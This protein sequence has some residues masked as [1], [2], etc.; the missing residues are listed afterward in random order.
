M[1]IRLLLI[2]AL[3]SSIQLYAQQSMYYVDGTG[4]LREH[5]G[6]KEVAFAG[7]NYTLPFAHAY[8]AHKQLGIDLKSAIDNDVYHLSRLGFNAFRLHVWDIEITD[9]EGNLLANEH[10]NLLDYLVSK[11]KERNIRIVL[12]PIAYWGNGYPERDEKKDGFSSRWDKC[13]ITRNE[14][15]IKAQENYLSQFMK[16]INPYTGI[17]LKDEPDIVGFEINN[18]PCNAASPK[19]TIAYVNRMSGAISKSG[20]HKP[21]FY[22]VSHN[23]QNTQAFY[24]AKIDG[25]TFQWYPTGLV[26]GHTR[27]GNFLPAVDRYPIP[28]NHIKNFNKKARLVYEFDAADIAAPYIYPAIART[29]RSAGFQWVTQFAYDP[30]GMAWANTEYQTHYLNL[31]YTPQKAI[32]MKIA[33]EVV[34][35]TPRFATYGSYPGDTLFGDFR[36]SYNERLSEMNTSEKFFYSNN[37]KAEPKDAKSL[38][39][40]AGYGNSPIVTY[41]GC[42]AYFIDK[43]SPGIWRLEVMPDAIWTSDPFAKT[44]LKKEV[45]TIHWKE[46]PIT[47]HLSDLGN[48]FSFAGLND[49]NSRKGDAQQ[50]TFTVYPGV[51]LLKRTGISDTSWNAGS[52]YKQI[53]LKEFA[54][55][56]ERVKSFTV[57]HQPVI[58]IDEGSDYKVKAT[59]VGPVVPDSAMLY[60]Y[61]KGGNRWRN[62]PIKMHR[63][64]GY[65]Y[66]ATIPDKAIKSGDL[67]YMIAVFQGI[68]SY[69]YPAACKGNPFDWDY[70]A[71]ETWNT[72]VEKQDKYITLLDAEKDYDAL[73]VFYINGKGYTKEEEAGKFPGEHSISIKITDPTANSNL[74]LRQFVKSKIDGRRQK[75][76]SCKSLFIK[77]NKLEGLDSL[78]I[79]FIT[80]DGFTYRK[81]VAVSTGIEVL[82]IPFT[83]LY[84]SETILQPQGYPAFLPE[85]LKPE[86]NI[87]LNIQNLE[88]LEIMTDKGMTNKEAGIQI[89]S[90][91]ME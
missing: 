33:A 44:S 22:N 83:Q 77:F 34:R 61:Y 2:I 78:S 7:T 20:C 21:V 47:I 25:G 45:A 48:S 6:N 68:A 55:P 80:S 36:V 40:I 63:T 85:V 75:L 53:R 15:A 17:A 13:E 71:T 89:M 87:P 50:S 16:H 38:K 26:A 1:K 37:T 70:C 69:T 27:Q 19:E 3:V 72:Q 54:A 76:A 11:L 64:T 84:L 51:Y 82:Q 56:A 62:H 18:E 24:D 90:A 52:S 79:G 39:E 29:F 23:F 14:T 5:A 91:W 74:L 81:R 30:M 60:M 10:L 67:H 43:L 66:E 8:R 46:W 42:G 4:V 58:A 65:E 9:A 86:M 28:F 12:T 59:I 32:S 88:F 49:G 35:R 57:L 31:A 41:E 73:E